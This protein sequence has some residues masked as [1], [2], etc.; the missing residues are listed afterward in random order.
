ML[1]LDDIQHILLTRTPAITGRYE[2]LTFDTPQGGR[3]WLTEL[4]DKVQSASDAVATMDES[5][6]WVTL[7][8]TWTGLRALGVDEESLASFPDAFR[9]GMTQRASILGDTGAA[10][11]EHWVGGLAGEDLH[12]IAILFSRTDEQCHRSIEEHDK[13]LDRTSG[14]RSLSYLDLNATPPFNYAHDHFG[15][16]DRLSQP[17]IKGSGE[18][19]TPGS[20]EPLEAGEFILGYADEDGPVANLPKPDVL[21]R[22]GSYMAYRRLQEH[23]VLFRDY[24]R[25]RSD[26]PEAEALLA[27]KFMGRWRSGAPLVLAPDRDDP[28]LGADP[29]RNNDFNYKEMDPFGYA[30]PLGSHARRLNPR[31]TGHYM[32]R[33]RMIRR[34]AT[35]GPALPDGA[36]DDGADRGIAAFIICADLVRQFEFAQNV[37]INDNTFHELGNEHDPICGTQ[38]GTLDFT[39]PKRPIRKVHKGLP[40]FTTLRGG[41]YFFLPGISALRYLAAEDGKATS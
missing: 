30:C 15:F 33:R 41:A 5:D 38:D 39:V 1:E 20:G 19:P 2:F 18:E 14:V 34:G 32:N 3:A 24:I 35:Y 7:A 26:T 31:D 9:E 17:V 8:F 27:A 11:P 22:N 25:E 10:A 12:A 16:R 40:A 37:W 36:P 13:L 21:S 28:E 29:M 4:L 6:R 23:V